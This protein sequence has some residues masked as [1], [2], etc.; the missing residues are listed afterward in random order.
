MLIY[1]RLI[2][3]EATASH[4]TAHSRTGFDNWDFEKGG[5][6]PLFFLFCCQYILAEVCSY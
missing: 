1:M 4:L 3:A 5:S 2:K 6:V